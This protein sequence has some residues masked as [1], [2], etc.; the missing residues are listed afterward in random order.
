VSATHM[1][2]SAEEDRDLAGR[3]I[4]VDG[5][6]TLLT[7]LALLTTVSALLFGSCSQPPTMPAL[8][9]SVAC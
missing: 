1:D 3:D 9:P 8:R 5:Y 6:R 4:I 7:E 2:T